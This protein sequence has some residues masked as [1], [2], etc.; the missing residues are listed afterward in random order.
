MTHFGVDAEQFGPLQALDEGQGVTDGG[1]QDVT[2]RLVRL[3]LDREP[4]VVA[5]RGHVLGEQVEGLLHGWHK[6]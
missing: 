5:L 1:Q 2:A 3:R 6:P 4:Q